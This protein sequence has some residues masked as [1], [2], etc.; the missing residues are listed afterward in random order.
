MMNRDSPAPIP[1]R[2]LPD[3]ERDLGRDSD[4]DSDSD[5]GDDRDRQ[6][7]AGFEPSTI[8]LVVAVTCLLGLVWGVIDDNWVLV[9][10][11]TP[12]FLALIGVWLF[13][14]A[15]RSGRRVAAIASAIGS[16][17]AVELWVATAVFDARGMTLA[18]IVAVSS[19]M[20]VTAGGIWAVWFTDAASPTS[21][22]SS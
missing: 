12:A 20:A 18:V 21:S 2:S 5:G 3:L 19:G 17:C 11:E 9:A 13:A 16:L 15:N 10:T 7:I 6:T 1:G 14:R 8:V 4:S 22:G